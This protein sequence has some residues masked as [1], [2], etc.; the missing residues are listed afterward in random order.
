MKGAAQVHGRAGW[1]SVA[2]AVLAMKMTMTGTLNEAMKPLRIPRNHRFVGD[3]GGA[4]D[5]VDRLK[6]R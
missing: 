2:G 5:L 4:G 1:P 6:H 3:F